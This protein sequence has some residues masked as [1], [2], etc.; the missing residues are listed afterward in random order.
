VSNM[1]WALATMGQQVPA[2]QLQ[3]LLHL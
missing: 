1:L 3:Q 2:R